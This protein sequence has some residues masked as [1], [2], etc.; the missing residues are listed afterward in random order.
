MRGRPSKAEES[1]VTAFHSSTRQKSPGCRAD[2]V[3][4]RGHLGCMARS[5]RH[6]NDFIKVMSPSPS[7]TLSVLRSCLH[8]LALSLSSAP[9]KKIDGNR[10]FLINIL[11]AW[12]V[13]KNHWL[14][15]NRIFQS[16]AFVPPHLNYNSYRESPGGASGTWDNIF[17][18][19]NHLG[20]SDCARL[21]RD[22]RKR[23]LILRRIPDKP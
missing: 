17:A 9:K 22:E 20:I 16:V 15:V 18:L 14:F 8:H 10:S 6:F 7:S 4:R 1:R 11:A 19:Y 12:I 2:K 3:R 5:Q 21:N 13:N 23:A